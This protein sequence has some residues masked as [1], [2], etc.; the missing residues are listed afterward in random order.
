MLNLIF[1]IIVLLML[2]SGFLVIF[3]KNPI[4]SILFLVLVFIG[5]T[6]L[7]ILLDVE[8]IAMLFLIVYVGAIT[9][10]FLFVVMMLNIKIIELA[11]KL[12]RYI[13][14]GGFIGLIFL[15]E[16]LFIITNNFQHENFAWFEN[17][18][19]LDN[20]YVDYFDNIVHYQNVQYLGE[21]LYTK[22][23]YLFIL[24][25]LIL[26]VS[27]VGSIILT[28][29]QQFKNKSQDI[30]TQTNRKLKDSIYYLN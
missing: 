17:R 1:S 10:L 18:P 28:L 15:L 25:G 11:E 8:F 19:S 20:T 13:P 22:Y 14:I 26:L 6:A 5:A 4:H 21:L 9:I 30:Y 16:I 24:A 7:L 27:M 2:V 3:S 12:I 23:V 29:N